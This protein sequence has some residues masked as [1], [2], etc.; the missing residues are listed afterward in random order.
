MW[1]LQM[2]LRSELKSQFR[3]SS[4]LELFS[5]SGLVKHKQKN[6]SELLFFHYPQQIGID[7]GDIPDLTQ[8]S[9]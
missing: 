6:I 9:S 7:K 2:E 5:I 1:I 3:C 4:Q 8:V